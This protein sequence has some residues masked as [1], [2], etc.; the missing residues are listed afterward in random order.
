MLNCSFSVARDDAPADPG[1]L[2]ESIERVLYD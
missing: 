1:R 2:D